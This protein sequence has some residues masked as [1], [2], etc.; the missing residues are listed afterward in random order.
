MVQLNNKL[1][2]ENKVRLSSNFNPGER[3]L[4]NRFLLQP[5]VCQQSTVENYTG[6]W[7]ES[8]PHYFPNSV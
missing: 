1:L 4:K 8:E 2:Y 3:R 6:K 5:S 7:W